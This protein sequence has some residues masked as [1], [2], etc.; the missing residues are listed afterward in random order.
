MYSG[1][2]ILATSASLYDPLGM[3]IDG[4]GNIYIC[5]IGHGRI[6]KVSTSGF[7][8]TVAGCDSFGYY[9]DGG[10]AT[11]ARLRSPFDV[12][13]DTNGDIYI[14]DE[15]NSNV[16]RVTSD[17]IIH[18]IAGMYGVSCTGNF[19]DNGLSCLS[20]LW[21]SNGLAFD[22]K[23]NLY[24]TDRD[25]SVIRKISNA[26]SLDD[27]GCNIT[28]SVTIVKN[29]EDEIQ[30]FP[31]PNHGHFTIAL[32]SNRNVQV[33]VVITNVLGEK[34][35]QLD[36]QTNQKNDMDIAV[37]RG[38]YFISGNSGN[39]KWNSKVFVD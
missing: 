27:T 30:V 11:N 19:G 22:G 14:A 38:V 16:R 35:K 26:T 36:I 18:T 8:T 23:W 1:D 4:D 5:D 3:A 34:I 10:P 39:N 33:S 25:L 21:G 17:G 20:C 28:A 37:P 15:A 12:K 24:I 29:T 9:G 7:I 31:N 13:L 32:I 6:R 2:N